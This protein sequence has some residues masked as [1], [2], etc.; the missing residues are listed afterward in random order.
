M[1]V[2]DRRHEPGAEAAIQL[3]DHAK[4]AIRHSSTDA[5]NGSAS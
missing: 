5:Y 4:T 1:A 3:Q 2:L